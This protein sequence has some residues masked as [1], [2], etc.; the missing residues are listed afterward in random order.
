MLQC[1]VQHATRAQHAH[2][3]PFSQHATYTE[4]GMGSPRPH[5]RRDLVE[6]G[7]VGSAHLFD[8]SFSQ[9]G[10]C[11]QVRECLPRVRMLAIDASA[12]ACVRA[13]TRVLESTV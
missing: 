9:V 6:Y 12:R 13:S 4:P 7:Q 5:L 8:L 3:I 1:K 10:R 2:G 11:I